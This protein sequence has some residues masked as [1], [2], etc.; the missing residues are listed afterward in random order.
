MSE[1]D[2]T[3]KTALQRPAT[4]NKE[5]WIAYW[6][7]QG[8]SWRTEPE[9]DAERRK[10]L[11]QQRSIMPDIQQG[12]YPFKGIELSRADIEWLLVTHENGRGP[13]DWNVEIQRKREGLDLRGA[14][15]NQVNL[16]G[17]PLTRLCGGL[18]PLSDGGS[19]ITEDQQA[20]AHIFM[21]GAS[22]QE[23]RLEG[24]DLSWAQLIGANLN[25]A[26]LTGA[27]LWMAK[28]E[29][30]HLGKAQLEGAFI[31]GTNLKGATLGQA[32]LNNANLASCRLEGADLSEAQ[33]VGANL[34]QARLSGANLSQAR[35]EGADLSRAQLVG[36][37]LTRARLSGANLSDAVLGDEQLIG[38]RLADVQWGDANLAAVD[39]S[40]VIMLRDEQW[41]TWLHDGD[42]RD[43]KL[44]RSLGHE[45]IRPKPDKANANRLKPWAEFQVAVR[46]NRQLA[47]AL[48]TQGLNEVAAHFAYRA[49]KLNRTVLWEQRK[50]GQYLF[51]LLLDLLAGYGYKPIRSLLAYLLIIFGF[52]CLF[53]LNA[54]FVAPHLRWD[55]ALVLSVSSFHGRG[56]FPQNIGLGDTFARLAA[57][58]AVIGLFIEISFIA[59]FT[60]RYFAS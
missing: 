28:L 23:T 43:R 39:W 31:L 8:Q 51:S 26:Y 12:I 46:A 4:D 49:L 6:K 19:E 14:I 18:G 25:E 7:E 24:A 47:I 44:I 10:Y 41:A 50:T 16:S 33:L 58:E 52:M 5:A 42:R 54:Q 57:A 36:A 21:D 2:S 30:A 9:I 29:N 32:Q 56:F 27:I 59:T 1:Q 3:Q 11:A 53:L 34:T 17:L 20:M 37:N 22:L 45:V 48:Q 38:P 15:L 35:L 40:Q 55:E 13:V 60:K